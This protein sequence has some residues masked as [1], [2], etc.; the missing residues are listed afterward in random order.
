MVRAGAVKHPEEWM[1][2]GYHEIQ[3]KPTSQYDRRPGGPGGCPGV[4]QSGGVTSGPPGVGCR[5]LAP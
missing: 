4:R 5:G 3:G 1:H 2:G